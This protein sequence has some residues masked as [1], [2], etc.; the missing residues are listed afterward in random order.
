MSPRWL[1]GHFHV[2]SVVISDMIHCLLKQC[3]DHIWSMN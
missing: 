1:F 2:I 3:D